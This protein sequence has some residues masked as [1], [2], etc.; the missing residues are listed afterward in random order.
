MKENND[1]F[2]KLQKM[3]DKYEDTNKGKE[4][5][6]YETLDENGNIVKKDSTIVAAYAY[7]YVN[8]YGD[9]ILNLILVYEGWTDLLQNIAKEGTHRGTC[10]N[11]GFDV[12][13]YALNEDDFDLDDECMLLYTNTMILM[14]KKGLFSSL[15][16]E[17]NSDKKMVRKF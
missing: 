3:V 2:E 8:E 9:K 10:D 1:L 5:L 7:Q 16:K 6:K 4:S 13:V 14:D 15:E 17:N 12:W 11:L